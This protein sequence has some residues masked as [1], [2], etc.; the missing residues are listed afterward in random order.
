MII[1]CLCP[2]NLL[3]AFLENHGIIQPQNRVRLSFSAVNCM[4]IKN[5]IHN[6]IITKGLSFYKEHFFDL[7]TI[8]CGTILLFNPFIRIV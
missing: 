1:F 4:N 5:L 6:C 2:Q 3:V 8:L 7:T